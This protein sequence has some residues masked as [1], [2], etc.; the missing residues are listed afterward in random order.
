MHRIV[1][2]CFNRQPFKQS[3]TVQ[4]GY[5]RLTVTSY[6][7]SDGQALH[8]IRVPA[9]VSVPFDNSPDCKYTE[10]ALGQADPKCLGCNWRKTV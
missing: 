3:V 8:N 4:D 9:M 1:Y 10:S 2:G 6:K 7:G 5:K